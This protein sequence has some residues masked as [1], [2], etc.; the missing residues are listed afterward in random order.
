MSENG[1]CGDTSLDFRAIA[2]CSV[3]GMAIFC[4]GRIIYANRALAELSGRTLQELLSFRLEDVFPLVHPEDRPLV[5]ETMRRR[6]E[7]APAQP[8]LEYR[9]YRGDGSLRWVATFS[10]VI[11]VGSSPAVVT[12]FT[13][14]TKRKRAE[15]HLRRTQREYGTLVENLPDMVARL[16]LEGTFRY[17]NRT[18]MNYSFRKPEEWIG[19]S[20]G[21]SW[22]RLKDLRFLNKAMQLVCKSSRPFEAEFQCEGVHG[23]M[24]LN[25]RLVPEPDEQGTTSGIL[26][27]ARDT[28]EK[29]RQ[30]QALRESR[31]HLR[32]L[33]AHLQE[34]REEERKAVAREIHDELGQL[35]TAVQLEVHRI[36]RDTG[37]QEELS[38]PERLLKEAMKSIRSICTSLRPSVLDHL[39]LHDAAKWLVKTHTE[40][41]SQRCFLESNLDGCSL[42]AP[43]ATAGFRIL[44]E[45][46]TN[47]ARHSQA[48]EVHVHL[49]QTADALRL[50]VSDNGAGMETTRLPNELGFGL[51]GMK[52]RAES[53][54]GWFDIQSTSF[55]GTTLRA[56]LPI[57][58]EN[59]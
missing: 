34:V 11:Q 55:Q 30:E 3:Q 13:D 15:D 23:P 39:G 38:E 14:I 10:S 35:I 27:I 53:L 32:R 40:R 1:S 17:V 50:T 6:L 58:Q 19:A 28:T 8:A 51:I 4:C 9:F 59:A 57:E 24:T 22:F 16:D 12:F 7:G 49:V 41:T 5:E 45:A 2:D 43:L 29:T 36:A 31:E 54:G 25:L 52:E 37:L 20:I 26:A 33:A 42:P 44:Q 47:A 18:V 21:K 46:L 48:S 56:E